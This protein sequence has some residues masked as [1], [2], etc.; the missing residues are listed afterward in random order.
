MHNLHGQFVSDHFFIASLKAFKDF[1][2]FTSS[3]ISS[4]ILGPRKAIL[5]VL[6]YTELTWGILKQVIW[7]KLQLGWFQGVKVFVK[8]LGITLLLLYTFLLREL[9][10]LDC[11][12]KQI[13]PCQA[14]F[15]MLIF[16]II[17]NT[18]TSF[19]KLVNP[20]I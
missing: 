17:N 18:R 2:C 1:F 19:M 4:Q 15:E 3:G 10:N 8:T 6:L 14:I 9:G 13:Y 5:S 12:S 20:V 11:V 16:V 7:R